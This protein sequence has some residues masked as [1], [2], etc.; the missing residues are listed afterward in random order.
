MHESLTAVREFLPAV[1]GLLPAVASLVAEHGFW[2]RE[3]QSTGSIAVVTGLVAP[4]H[5][6]SSRNRGNTRF[7]FIGSRIFSTE[8]PEKSYSKILG[9]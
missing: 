9:L 7:A 1:R 8:P 2:A 4:W 6:G 3:L 5:V